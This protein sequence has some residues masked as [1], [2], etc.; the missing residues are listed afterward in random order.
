MFCDL[1]P[2]CHG[3]QLGQV[4]MVQT[5]RSSHNKYTYMCNIKA[6]ISFGSKVIAK[7]KFTLDKE[8]LIPIQFVCR[9]INLLLQLHRLI[10]VKHLLFARTLFSR[11]FA[12][13]YR[14]ENKVLANYFLYKGWRRKH[15]N[16][17][18]NNKC[19][20]E[21]YRLIKYI[22]HTLPW[23]SEVIDKNPSLRRLGY[24]CIH[25]ESL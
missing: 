19:F 1:W 14:R 22:M 9:G 16:L 2:S 17:N 6:P 4:K 18:A 7:D 13:A 5:E 25:L 15:E 23:L 24:K 21:L 12:R 10:T 20:T 3:Q 8:R 11:K